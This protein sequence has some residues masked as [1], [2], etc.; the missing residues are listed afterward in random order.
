M[1]LLRSMRK[2][3]ILVSHWLCRG[4]SEHFNSGLDTLKLFIRPLTLS[5]VKMS[6]VTTWKKMSQTQE[7]N[8]M[9]T[10]S[11]WRKNNLGVGG[12]GWKLAMS[13]KH[14]CVRYVLRRP[15]AVP[16]RK[17]R[18]ASW[19]KSWAHGPVFISWRALQDIKGEPNQLMTLPKLAILTSEHCENSEKLLIF[20]HMSISPPSQAP[21]SPT[22]INEQRHKTEKK[23]K[24]KKSSSRK[25]K[26]LK[27]RQ[28]ISL[29]NMLSDCRLISTLLL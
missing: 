26:T 27:E 16:K 14:W 19:G 11:W 29:Y 21:F 15:W 6:V 8:E 24:F 7:M 3:R 2:E 13:A 17:E 1:W 9:W 20:H 22:K 12:W 25:P 5:L 23:M 18:D 4:I 28:K 10:K